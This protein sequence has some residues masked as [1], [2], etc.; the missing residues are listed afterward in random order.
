MQRVQFNS[1]L[2]IEYI[3]QISDESFFVKYPI[4]GEGG[5]PVIAVTDTFDVGTSQ[6]NGFSTT[7]DILVGNIGDASL[8]IAAITG[9]N[10]T[11]FSQTNNC[12]GTNVLIAPG[13]TCIIAVNFVASEF[14][15]KAATLS[16]ES[17]GP[18]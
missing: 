14:G 10:S 12:I 15:A 2:N 18:Q 13:E 3:S 6:V 17:N 7:Q 4:V 1:N 16:I 8:Q 5:L 9:L 11:K